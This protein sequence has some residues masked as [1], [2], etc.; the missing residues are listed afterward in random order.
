V[1]HDTQAVGD[2]Q[3]Q[4]NITLA[5]IREL[6]THVDQQQS[7][8]SAIRVYLRHP[9]HYEIAKSFLEQY[10]SLDKINF[11]HADICREQLL[12]EIEALASPV[13]DL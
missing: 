9:H 11:L 7:A 6:V 8:L 2:L 3:E 10:F 4:L 5:N 13:D 1:G 12:V